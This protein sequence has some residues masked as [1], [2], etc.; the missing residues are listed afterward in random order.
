[1][2]CRKITA[3]LL[4]GCVLLLLTGC[5]SKNKEIYEQ[6]AA[7]LANGHYEDAI[8]GYEQ[9]I[10]G[11]EYLP[12]AYRGQG[13]AYYEAG[14]Y[15]KA[16]DAFEKALRQ[17]D[18]GK[19]FQKDVLLYQAAACYKEGMFEMAWE[20]CQKALEL[21]EDAQVRLLRGKVALARDDYEE[22]AAC[23]DA[24]YEEEATFDMAVWIYNAYLER[25]M[26]AD[27]TAYLE[28]FLEKK[29]RKAEDYCSRGEIYYYMQ[30]YEHARTELAE[31]VD[32]GSDDAKLLLG[33][34]YLALKDTANA[35][36]MYQEYV[37][38]ESKAALGYNGLA[39]CAI[40][41]GDYTA[42]LDYVQKGLRAAETEELQ[43][44]MYNEAV[45][46]EKKLDFA[47]ALEKFKEYLNL[48]PN[49]EA[50]ERE[51]HFLMSRMGGQAAGITQ[52]DGDEAQKLEPVPDA[53]DMEMLGEADGS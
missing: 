45:I 4:A 30:D 19:A 17:E 44:L 42:A 10:S 40:G 48:Y 28:R 39:L 8:S 34:V 14:E 11:E 50:A 47:T 53:G 24:A 22:A 18:T 5:G 49:D 41:D 43:E 29:P 2:K 35:R 37:D 9:V 23:F 33:K 32:Q 26:E 20:A 46:Y 21:K 6:A 27:G 36:I 12:E 1:M 38:V 52:D 13:I 25:D 3:V 16:S 31:A 7:D 15:V 51:Y